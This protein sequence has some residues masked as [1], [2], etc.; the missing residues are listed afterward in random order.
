MTEEIKQ[1]RETTGA[2]VMDCKKALD[3][4][5][6]DTKR[7]K[8][9]IQ[10]KGLAKAAKK[11]GRATGTGYLETYIHTGRI[12]VLLEMRCETDFVAKNEDFKKLAHELAM[13][14]AAMSAENPE[15]LASQPYIKDESKTV[16]Q[17]IKETI[18]KLGENIKVERFC[19]YEV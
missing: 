10:E 3:E 4:A 16:E 13:Q 1:L 11:G 19:R 12:G 17:L 15:E 8:E 6:G 2:G 14:I 5:S 9:I 7:A 18:A